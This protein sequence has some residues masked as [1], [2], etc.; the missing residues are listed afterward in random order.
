MLR[1][2]VREPRFSAVT[3]LTLALALAAVVTV[4]TLVN[5]VLL[6]QLP[7]PESSHLV[8]LSHAAPGL[9]LDKMGVSP[10]LYLHY[11]ERSKTLDGIALS[12]SAEFTLSGGAEEPVRVPG[13]VVSPSAFRLLRVD[14]QLG[15]AFNEEEGRP[16]GTA[17]VMLSH[18]LWQRRYG[19]EA[20]I[21]GRQIL[22]NGKQREVVGV[23]PA[24]FDFP[25]PTTELWVP[26]VFDRAKARLGYF[27][28]NAVARVR[29]P[30]T[31]EA[32][33]NELTQLTRDLM[34]AF[35]DEEAA[36]TLQDA[37]LRPVLKTLLESA[38]GEVRPVLWA[39]LAAAGL[40][41]AIACAN[42]ANLFLVRFEE[43][44]GELAI[45]GALGA[46]RGR[47]LGAL[48][49]EG[50]ALAA[51]AGGVAGVLA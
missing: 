9:K 2:L 41:L 51:R 13:A 23:M 11:L 29:S 8:D 35:P 26:R 19:G 30:V 32:A 17:V 27:N 48:F 1:R 10:R 40:I 16:G 49:A 7:Y 18:D 34:G 42:V 15:R 45:R 50:L 44:S 33:E 39:L 38:V 6:R 43:R 20:A 47:Q 5:A 31:V 36:K 25:S 37:G 12:S 14:P 3:V 28:E 4:F 46:S 21:V 24:G 22:V